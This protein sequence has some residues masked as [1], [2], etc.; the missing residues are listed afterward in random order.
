MLLEVLIA[1][2]VLATGLGGLFSLI[3]ASMYTNNTSSTDTR[4]TMLAEHV[5]E[6]ISA[7][8]ANACGTTLSIT[9]CAGTSWTIATGAAGCSSI[10]AGNGGSNG[11][12]GANLTSNGN[13][14]WTQAYSSIPAGYAMK[15]VS[16]GANG[17]QNTYDVRW[18]VIKMSTYSRMVVISAR[19][20]QA[21]TSGGL[22]FILPVNLRTIGGM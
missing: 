22:R 8:P 6:Q 5:L 20:A 4:A 2:V 11:G 17:T 14:D 10:G 3:A 7:Q 1:M 12:D 9:D 19:P 15:Y 13:I 16:C 18:D 21:P